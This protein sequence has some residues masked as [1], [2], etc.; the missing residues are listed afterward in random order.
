M[1]C[2]EVEEDDDSPEETDTEYNS[3]FIIVEDSEDD[4]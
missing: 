2:D 1:L 4:E 3:R